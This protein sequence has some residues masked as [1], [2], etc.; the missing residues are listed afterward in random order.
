MI[1]NF[2]AELSQAASESIVD[3][4]CRHSITPTRVAVCG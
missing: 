3:D 1:A 4:V 2:M